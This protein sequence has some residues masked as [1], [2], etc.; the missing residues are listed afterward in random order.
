MYLKSI[1]MSLIERKEKKGISQDIK[2]Y[3]RLYKSRRKQISRCCCSEKGMQ[4]NRKK[5]QARGTF[6]AVP[7]YEKI[8]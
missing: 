6:G 7:C 4:R 3:K 8:T 1:P 2:A 5:N